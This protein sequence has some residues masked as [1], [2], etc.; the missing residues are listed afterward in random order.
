MPIY[1]YRCGACEHELEKL[2]RMN[3]DKLVDCPACSQPAL[4]RLVSAAAFRLKG[5]GW[6]ETDFKKDNRK[7]LADKKEDKS[8]GKDQKINEKAPKKDTEKKKNK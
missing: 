2:Q 4:K 5:S 8:S 3:D 7:N 6:Y 1:E